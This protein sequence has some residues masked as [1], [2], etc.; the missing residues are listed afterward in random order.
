MEVHLDMEDKSTHCT[1]LILS[2]VLSIVRL[3]KKLFFGRAMREEDL[4]VVPSQLCEAVERGMM[5]HLNSGFFVEYGTWCVM[6]RHFY[7]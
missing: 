2:L 1:W 3:R 6:H 4:S 7:L 5:F